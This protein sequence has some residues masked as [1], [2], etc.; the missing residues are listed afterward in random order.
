VKKIISIVPS[1][2]KVVEP[3]EQPKK[4]IKKRPPKRKFEI[5]FSELNHLLT[6]D[7]KVFSNKIGCF[8]DYVL[9]LNHTSLKLIKQQPVQN[10]E[11]PLNWNLDS[12]IALCYAIS[13]SSAKN[14]RLN[15]LK[16]ASWI[17]CF[18]DVP[19][20]RQFQDDKTHRISRARAMRLIGHFNFKKREMVRAGKSEI[21]IAKWALTFVLDIIEGFRGFPKKDDPFVLAFHKNMLYGYGQLMQS[22]SLNID[23]GIAEIDTTGKKGFIQ[24]IS[25]IKYENA[26]EI[27]IFSPFVTILTYSDKSKNIRYSF[28]ANPLNR[29]FEQIDLTGFYCLVN[30]LYHNCEGIKHSSNNENYTF[31]SGNSKAGATDSII[32]TNQLIWRESLYE[33]LAQYLKNQLK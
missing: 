22:P 4:C 26:K 27:S 7:I 2:N 1:G 31:C 8:F 12:V 19:I 28:F 10:V 11:F 3:K 9:E 24:K 18:G 5:S 15:D 17:T 32:D 14:V 13:K 20:T 33:L 29:S 23:C 30:N 16:Y 21:V 25:I 6:L